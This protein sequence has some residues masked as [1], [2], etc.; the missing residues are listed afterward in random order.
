MFRRFD[1]MTGVGSTCIPEGILAPRW[2]LAYYCSRPSY[3]F[4]YGETAS[5]TV[6][7][8]TELKV[9]RLPNPSGLPLGPL[10]D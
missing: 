1:F 9:I 7:C 4:G 5:Y 8:I 10:P 2:S 6:R 3:H